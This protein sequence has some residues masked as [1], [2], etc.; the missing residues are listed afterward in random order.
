VR[1]T[2]FPVSWHLSSI[3]NQEFCEI[4]EVE[5]ALKQFNMLH[6]YTLALLSA[7]NLFL[8]LFS[9]KNIAQV[10]FIEFPERI[11]KG[12]HVRIHVC[13]SLTNK[14]FPRRN[15]FSAKGIE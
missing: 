4:V 14:I 7:L 1:F 15:I 3:R 12:L 9:C 13:L 2:D 5:M 10:C 11:E 8:V 6:K